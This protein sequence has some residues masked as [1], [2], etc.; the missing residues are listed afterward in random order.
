MSV[1]ELTAKFKDCTTHVTTHEKS[2]DDDDDDDVN[3]LTNLLKTSISTH[4]SEEAWNKL[5]NAENDSLRLMCFGSDNSPGDSVNE[6][7]VASLRKLAHSYMCACN[8]GLLLLL[9][10]E[11]QMLRDVIASHDP[12]VF[13]VKMHAFCVYLHN[14]KNREDE[15]HHK[16][17]L[18]QKNRALKVRKN[19]TFKK[20]NKQNK[21][22]K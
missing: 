9:N 10:K 11:I 14:E 16:K 5:L 3:E 21:Q 6:R 8:G 17:K 19:S 12:S 20:K 4:D 22:N 13:L 7:D 2:K 15:E 18:A 1:E